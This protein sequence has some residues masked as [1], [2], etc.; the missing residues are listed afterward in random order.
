MDRSRGFGSPSDVFSDAGQAAVPVMIRSRIDCRIMFLTDIHTHNLPSEAGSA[1]YCLP[2]GETNMP[3]AQL[4]SVGIH[5]WNAAAADEISYAWVEKMLSRGNVV[6]L[7]EVGLD[8]LHGPAIELQKGVFAR[9]AALSEQFRKPLVIHCVKSADILLSMRKNLHSEM[10][11]VIHG[12]RGGVDL[13]RQLLDNG[14]S[15]SFGIHANPETLRFVGLDRI[16]V[17]TD[18]YSSIRDVILNHASVLGVTYEHALDKAQANASA[19]FGA[20][21]EG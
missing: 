13:A 12:F 18:N 14:L 1:I 21:L 16:L 5:P 7:G 2:L 8:R 17:E 9:Q 3:D 10:P 6:S 4:C 19:F 20:V 15:I 11:W